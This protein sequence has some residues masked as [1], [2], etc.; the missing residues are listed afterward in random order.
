MVRYKMQQKYLNEAH[1]LYDDVF[2]IVQM[3]L[4]TE[5]VRGSEKLKSFSEM[6]VNPY[7]PPPQP[8]VS[9]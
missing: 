2:H 5:E 6:L 4:L 7:T 9:S 8:V 3:P 1:E